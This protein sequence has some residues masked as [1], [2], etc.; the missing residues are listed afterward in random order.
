MNTRHPALAA[1]ALAT[2]LAGG[3][4][5]SALTAQNAAAQATTAPQQTQQDRERHHSASRHIDGRIAFLK[6]EL[7]ITDAQ[8]P[9]FD[10]V[11]QAMRQNAQAIDQARQQMHANRDQPKNAVERLETR[12]RFAALRA[13]SSQR[14]LDAFKPLYASLSDDQKKAADEMLAHHEH[15]GHEHGRL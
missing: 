15:H 14:F 3:V 6:T 4:G 13:Q 9:Q 2:A 1:L 8:A 11:A 7:K 5:L 10:R 12:T